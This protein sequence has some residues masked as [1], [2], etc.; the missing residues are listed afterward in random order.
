M[1]PQTKCLWKEEEKKQALLSHCVIC[2]SNNLTTLSRAIAFGLC[3]HKSKYIHLHHAPPPLLLMVVAER[4][5]LK[6][7]IFVTSENVHGCR[8][9]VLQHLTAQICAALRRR[10]HH[11]LCLQVN[12]VTSS[13]SSLTAPPLSSS[14]PPTR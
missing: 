5:Q 1:E 3:L 12:I 7:A 13:I 2:S 10:N 6:D 4:E 8:Y 11:Q 14:A 9:T